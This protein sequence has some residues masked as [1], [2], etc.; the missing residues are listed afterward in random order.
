M[1]VLKR[2]IIDPCIPGLPLSFVTY[3]FS[4]YFFMTMFVY[5]ESMV[6]NIT[7]NV[8]AYVKN[9]NVYKT[10]LMVLNCRFFQ[11]S[12]CGCSHDTRFKVADGGDCHQLPLCSNSS[13]VTAHPY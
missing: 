9:K 7:V 12:P 2:G 13:D 4:T 1:T 11:A 8:V 10:K 5:C 6:W 3:F